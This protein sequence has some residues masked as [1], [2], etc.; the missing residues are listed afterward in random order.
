MVKI[1]IIQLH[2]TSLV[3]PHRHR[4]TYWTGWGAEFK[5][6][7]YS[8]WRTN[9]VDGKYLKVANFSSII[10][11]SG[12]GQAVMEHPCHYPVLSPSPRS[13]VG[14]TCTW[15]WL[16]P[17]TIPWC[18]CSASR[19]TTPPTSSMSVRLPVCLSVQNTQIGCFSKHGDWAL[20][21]PIR[22]LQGH[23][24]QTDRYIDRWTK[25]FIYTELQIGSYCLFRGEKIKWTYCLISH[26]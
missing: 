3:V 24:G 25:P 5:Q 10:M 14:E 9:T 11:G 6:R 15:W 20:R 23:Y 22:V 18:H 4:S 1:K 26:S 8:V 12:E 16:P 21:Q 19:L 7:L 2:F 13:G 17:A